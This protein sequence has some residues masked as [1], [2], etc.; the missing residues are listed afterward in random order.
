MAYPNL[1]SDESIVLNAQNVKVKS[2]SFE[3]VLTTRRL[4]LVDSKKHLIAP[5]EILLATLRDIEAGENAIRDPTITL[6]IITTTGATRQMILTFSKTSGGDRRR[7]RD[8]WIKA[9]RLNMASAGQHPIMPDQPVPEEVY[10]PGADER[11]SPVRAPPAV[12]AHSGKKKI[13]IARPGPIKKI[14]D[15]PP[16][17]PKPVETTSLP[18]GSF[19]NKCGSRVPP[20]SAFCNK[21][22][23]PV[24]T[25]A[26]LDAHLAA[27]SAPAPSVPQIQ[28]QARPT[29]GQGDKKERPIEEVIHS[30]EPLIEDSVPRTQPYPIVPKQVFQPREQQV[31]VPE[32]QEPSTETAPSPAPETAAPAPESPTPGVNW[33]VLG[34]AGGAVEG[35]VSIPAQPEGVPAAAPQA[36]PVPPVPPVPAAPVGK[37][38]I[39]VIGAVALVIVLIIAAVF[40]FANPL[41]GGPAVTTTP[42]PTPVP[43]TVA[44]PTPSTPTMTVIPTATTPAVEPAETPA[45]STSSAGG[46]MI[47]PDQNVWIHIIYDG[48][49]NGIYGVAGGSTTIA[50]EGEKVLQIPVNVGIVIASI[51]KLDGSGDKLTVE[52][53]KDG[54][55]VVEKSTV[56]PKGVVEIQ[57]D[58]R[59][60][61]TPTPTPTATKIPVPTKTMTAANETANMTATTTAAAE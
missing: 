36:P 3:A 4:I 1:Y 48:E 23:T 61:S 5:Q 11:P 59:P 12:P 19:C 54:K 6:S 30:I 10:P 35:Q 42:E 17:I 37:K 25:D 31:A 34:S 60:T 53:W 44:T 20:D 22:G 40:I 9:L 41:G 24:V 55:L 26:D 8:E 7:E 46:K 18:T 16:A 39:M 38:K 13:E 57:A 52:I 32:Q 2:V 33:P 14:I 56:S 15:A 21:C 28:V 49:Y 27:P 58:L 47:V 45:G 29:F 50:G 43:T 51:Q